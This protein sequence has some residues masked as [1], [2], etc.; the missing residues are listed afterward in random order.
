MNEHEDALVAE[1]KALRPREPAAELKQ[2]IAAE[3]DALPTVA[4]RTEREWS[5][6]TMRAGARVALA[7]GLIAAAIAI[8]FILPRQPNTPVEDDFTTADLRP[9]V[10]SAFDD[11]LPSLWQFHSALSRSE[12]EVNALLDRHTNMAREADTQQT[13]IRGFGRF[14]TTFNNFPGEL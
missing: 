14:D 3:L 12:S 9:S 2:R 8:A 7:T 1:L 5:S 4:K 13:P 11:A 10:A 6:I